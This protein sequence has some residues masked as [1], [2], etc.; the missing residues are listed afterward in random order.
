MT[1][2]VNI[3]KGLLLG[4]LGIFGC[5]V[6]WNVIGLV[7]LSMQ[8]EA[9]RGDVG[10]VWTITE[11]AIELLPR[12]ENDVEVFMKDRQDLV[13]LI[14]IARNDFLAAEKSGNL[15][16]LSGVIDAVMAIQV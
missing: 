10:R 4:V 7:T 8:R 16:Q 9:V 11:R 1:M 12:L 3:N 13:E 15:D 5:A 2:N 6:V 14:T